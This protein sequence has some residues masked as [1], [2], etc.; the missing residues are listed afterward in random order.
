MLRVMWGH[1]RAPATTP[2]FV[3]TADQAGAAAGLAAVPPNTFSGTAPDGTARG[4][5]EHSFHI[6]NDRVTLIGSNYASWR[7]RADEGGPKILTDSD[8]DDVSGT[9][10]TFGGG[11]G[12]LTDSTGGV[13]CSTAYNGSEARP[14]EREFGCG[15]GRTTSSVTHDGL[16]ITHTTAVMPG[17]D[18]FALIEATVTNAGSETQRVSYHEVWGTG[19]VHQLTGHGWGGWSRW[20]N[21]STML[22][23]RAFVKSHYTS[24]YTNFSFATPAGVPVVGALQ[25]RAWQGLTSAERAFFQAS[26]EGTWPLPPGASLWDKAP[27]ALFLATLVPSKEARGGAIS[28]AIS[29]ATSRGGTIP[30]HEATFPHETAFSHVHM[31]AH[32]HAHMHVHAH[33]R[34]R[35]RIYTHVHACVPACIH[36]QVGRRPLPTW[37]SRRTATPHGRFLEGAALYA[38]A[39]RQVPGVIMCQKARRPSSPNPDL[40]SL[41]TR[42]RRSSS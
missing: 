35:V 4:L 32:M 27:P 1:W 2:A 38:Q 23:R 33:A 29:R 5:R 15:F 12:Y 8:I 21:A 40:S 3:Y 36:A 22:D 42:R 28:R 37:A 10:H 24:T 18:P 30:H 19:M 31:H 6:G 20:H 11:L 9:S 17:R 7:L 41:L 13:V 16:S 14:R 34:M 39:A 26:Y 25:S